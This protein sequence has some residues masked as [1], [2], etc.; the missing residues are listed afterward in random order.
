M[1]LGHRGVE[2][3]VKE[4]QAAQILVTHLKNATPRTLEL[5]DA[6]QSFSSNRISELGMIENVKS[7]SEPNHGGERPCIDDQ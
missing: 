3:V 4:K 7:D 5:R 6:I 1:N 2:V